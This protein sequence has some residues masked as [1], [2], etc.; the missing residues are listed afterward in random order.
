MTHED[1][2]ARMYQIMHRIAEI[3][4]E[5]EM[6]LRRRDIE[7]WKLIHTKRARGETH[8]LGGHKSWVTRRA[9]LAARK[10]AA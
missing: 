5:R 9:N 2:I 1:K 6:I 8:V 4:C 10:K 3:E 7:T